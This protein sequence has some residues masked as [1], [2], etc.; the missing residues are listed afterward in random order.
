M[1]IEI[2]TMGDE[3]MSG[4]T[5][6]SNF[7]WSGD[8]LSSKGFDI[9][10]HTTV[11]DDRE[12]ITAAFGA[13]RH[14]ADAV[15]VSGGLGPT[16]DDLTAE[17]AAR[18]FEAPLELNDEALK[19]ILERL[20][21]R[22]R[23]LSEMNKRQAFLPRGSKV[24]VNRWGTAPGFSIEKGS[25]VFYFL[26]GVPKE[27]RAMMNEY[28]VPE[29]ESGDRSRKPFRTKLIKT[30]G[31][32]ESEVAIRLAGV[33]RKGVRLGYRA[34]YPEVH[35]RVTACGESDDSAEK[36]MTEFVADVKTRLGRYLFSTEG[37]TMEEV[38][39]TLLR[40]HGM[41]LSTAESCTGGLISDRITDVPGSSDYFLEGVVSYS[42][43]AK[44]KILGVP[45]DILD[46]HG[47]V[48][49]PVV[50]AMAQ[51][52][53]RLAGSD[54][55]VGVSG[56]AGPG[57]G[58]AEKPVGTV[59]IGVDSRSGGTRSEKFFFHGTREEIKL[60]TSSHALRLIMQIF[61]NNV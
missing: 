5:Q 19:S 40:Q 31:L 15:I 48:S 61:L 10:F 20:E 18:F 59:Y 22:G 55:G 47:A 52:V 44:E 50:E 34:H 43:E 32:P 42:N 53:R 51:G 11:G 54:I 39:G 25:T 33:E 16:S 23:S 17:V 41:K 36:L 49:A 7:S 3:L 21:S 6:D 27:F 60:V 35:L 37:E 45:K 28:V 56:I 14:R 29:L 46:A 12:R 9:S 26:P 30:F 1:R 8:L 24:L 38:V 57:G 4:L 58:S 2:I 13:A